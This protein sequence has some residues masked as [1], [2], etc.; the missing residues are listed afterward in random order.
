MAYQVFR[1]RDGIT[2]PAELEARFD[3]EYPGFSK[4]PEQ[5][6]EVTFDGDGTGSTLDAERDPE[7]DRRD[8]ADV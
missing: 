4:K 3:Q 6:P 5:F 7:R 1:E 2:D 8:Q